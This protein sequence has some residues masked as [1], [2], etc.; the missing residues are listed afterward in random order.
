MRRKI[1]SLAR[2]GAVYVEAGGWQPSIVAHTCTIAAGVRSRDDTVV[3][4][5]LVA[6]ASNWMQDQC[7]C[8]NRQI[9][10]TDANLEEIKDT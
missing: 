1:E 4:V 10:T 5:V 6:A 3:I 2:D 7:C 8:D 9:W